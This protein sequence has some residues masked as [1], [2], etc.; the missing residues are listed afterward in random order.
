MQVK[1]GKVSSPL[2]RD[3]RGT[4]DREKAALGLS[5][6]PLCALRVLCGKSSPQNPAPSTQNLTLPPCYNTP[7]ASPFSADSPYS[8]FEATHK[9]CP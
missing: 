6:T 7:Q 5:L 1:S 2:I 4:V 3:L 9:E 8:A